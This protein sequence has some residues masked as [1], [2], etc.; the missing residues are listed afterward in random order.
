MEEDSS[1]KVA[2]IFTVFISI[3]L[4]LLFF[5]VPDIVGP[6]DISTIMTFF[7]ILISIVPITTAA[8]IVLAVMIIKD[9]KRIKEN[10]AQ[11]Q[12]WKRGVE[13]PAQNAQLSSQQPAE[14]PVQQS[15]DDVF[16][17]RVRTIGIVTVILLVV[18]VPIVAD[19]IV[20]KYNVNIYDSS[21]KLWSFL[22]NPV[23]QSILLPVYILVYFLVTEGIIRI[24]AEIKRERAEL[25]KKKQEQ[26]QQAPESTPEPAPD[27]EKT[28]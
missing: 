12:D 14:Q 23:W 19:F 17:K 10:K 3:L 21:N 5:I 25:E 6:Q 7:V 27:Q 13:Q 9:K 26:N 1:K 28:A 11:L 18:V 22:S 15:A 4:T 16:K 20:K 24:R 8:S 2:L